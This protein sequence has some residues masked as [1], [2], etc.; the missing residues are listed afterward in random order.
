MIAI[1]PDG[2]VLVEVRGSRVA[3]L[4]GRHANAV[5]QFHATGDTRPLREF[6]GRSV[7]GRKLATDPNVLRRL[8]RRGEIEF[9]DIYDLTT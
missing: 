7:Q 1:T 4:I 8:A 6:R 9:E 3:S 2:Q 5:Q